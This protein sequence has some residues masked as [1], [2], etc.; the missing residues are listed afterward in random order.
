MGMN[1]KIKN[2]KTVHVIPVDDLRKHVPKAKCWCFPITMFDGVFIHNAKDCREA[3]ERVG[4]ADLSKG[5]ELWT[6][7]NKK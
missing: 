7:K 4:R 1:P 3:R 2:A 5:W 6:V